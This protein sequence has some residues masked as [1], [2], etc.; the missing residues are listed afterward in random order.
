[1]SRNFDDIV[2]LINDYRLHDSG[3]SLSPSSSEDSSLGESDEDDWYNYSEEEFNEGSER[4]TEGRNLEEIN[5]EIGSEQS[6]IRPNISWVDSVTANDLLQNKLDEDD[7]IVNAEVVED[8]KKNVKQPFSEMATDLAS[9]STIWLQKTIA[10][11]HMPSIGKPSQ[12]NIPYIK[13]PNLQ[14]PNLQIPNLQNFSSPKF[15][16]MTFGTNLSIPRPSIPSMPSLNMNIEF[17]TLPVVTFP[18]IIPGGFSS[19]VWDEKSGLLRQGQPPQSDQQ[20]DSTGFG[21]FGYSW[22][23]NGSQQPVV[24]MYHHEL[25]EPR[26]PSPSIN[27]T[28]RVNRKVG[29]DLSELNDEQ[30]ARVEHHEEKYRR[31]KKDRMLYL[32]WVPVLFG[33]S[34]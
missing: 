12:I 2:T 23:F 16:T 25:E 32:F 22:P 19:F 29:Y 27:N 20:K 1:M 9:A 5:H 13:M 3:V 14:M 15:S 26:T 34:C 18:T 33:M 17:P 24:P 11:M 4:Q 8:D 21:K 31:L 30:I 10:H 7:G 6:K 28:S